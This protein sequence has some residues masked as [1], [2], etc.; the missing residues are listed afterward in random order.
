[1][2][3]YFDTAIV[4]GGLYGCCLA[5][6]LQRLGG[7]VV[8][9][10]AGADLLQRASYVNQARV[11][12]GYHYPRSILTG[13]R[14]RI[15]FPRF[16]ADYKECI[17]DSFDKYYAIA[18]VASNVNGAQFEK[19][20]HRIGAPIEPAPS[21]IIELFEPAMI[22]AVFT[23]REYAFDAL[24]LAEK[25]RQQ[26][27]QC[28]VEVRL[29]HE[30]VAV[31]K[32]REGTIAVS[33]VGPDDAGS[34]S[35]D[36]VL[37]CTYSRTNKLLV[38]SGLEPIPL[39]HELT[40][41]AL[42]EVPEALRSLGITVMCGPFFSLMPFPPLG[43]HTLS[44]VRYTP[45]CEWYDGTSDGFQ[46]P[47]A[48]F[49]RWEKRSR[50]VHMQKDAQRFLPIIR[51]CRYLDSLWEVKTVLPRSELDDS[52]PILLRQDYGIP[53]LSCV[54]G[55]KIDNVY[56]VLEQVAPS[57]GRNVRTTNADF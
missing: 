30:V 57:A 53:H 50:F 51:D 5:I 26:L 2:A 44:H 13:V 22:E 19:F 52:R 39:K 12:G 6:H 47:Y 49:E 17:V 21:E 33:F 1:M 54:M 3:K 37:N 56:D 7:R 18:K 24:V 28:Q 46:D 9:L 10:E 35:V 27:A 23:V 34:M 20:C 42:V 11:H 41:M 16:V 45:H 8:I 29:Q 4:G 32:T 14:S 15:N 40:E 38:D 25:L 55:S 31:E 48:V 36:R 43:V